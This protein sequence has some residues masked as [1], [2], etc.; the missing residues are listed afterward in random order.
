M[1]STDQP[2]P[3][4]NEG[5][6]S[7]ATVLVVEDQPQMRGLVRDILQTRYRV[8]E[9]GDGEEGLQ[10]AIAERPD[11]VVADMMMP[12]LSGTE[13]LLQMRAH[14]ALVDTPVILLT[15]RHEHNAAASGLQAGANDYIGKPFAPA[16]LLARVEVQLRLRDL[17]A[18][19]AQEEKLAS[20]GLIAAGFS[21]EVLNPLNGILNAV[22]LLREQLAGASR[23]ESTQVLLDLLTNCGERIR[24]LAQSVLKVGRPVGS[25]SVDDVAKGIESALEVLAWRKPKE[26][27]LDCE[28]SFRGQVEADH[29]ELNQVWLNLLDNALRA[30]GNEGHIRVQTKRADDEV[31]VEISD[32]GPGVALEHRSRLFQPF[33]TTRPAGEG[34]GLGLTLVRR[35]VTKHGGRIE[36]HSPPG[37]GATFTVALPSR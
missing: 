16:E 13:L 3:I 1:S 30:V 11:V 10:R 9:A 6:T 15:A 27:E 29:A 24:H 20:L 25:R 23:E 17:A 7:L 26:V 22:P 34:T 5:D 35:I 31:L 21:H 28:L 36:L 19:L 14:P 33:F 2:A 18:R 12:K 32:S 37:A 4:P 8:L